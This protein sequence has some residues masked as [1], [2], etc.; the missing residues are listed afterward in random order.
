MLLFSATLFEEIAAESNRYVHKK[1]P[2]QNEPA[3]SKTSNFVSPGVLYE[4]N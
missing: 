2:V 3:V 4:S 1:K